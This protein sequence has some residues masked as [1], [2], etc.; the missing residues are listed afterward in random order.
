[1]LADLNPSAPSGS[2]STMHEVF[3]SIELSEETQALITQNP[4][5]GDAL[6]RLNRSLLADAYPHEL[7]S[8]SAEK[9]VEDFKGLE[10]CR[11]NLR[12]IKLALEN[13]RAANA[14]RDPKWLSELSPEY[15]DQRK[16]Y[17]CPADVTRGKPGV[18]TEGAEDASA[19]V[20]LPLCVSPF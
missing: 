4:K 19:A 10:T 15:L 6:V 3:T 20:Q 11:E 17:C 7:A 14:D 12:Q 9:R 16:C 18:L 1:M 13:Y 2:G 8:L 5:N